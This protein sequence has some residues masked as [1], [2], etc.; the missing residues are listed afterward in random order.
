MG[1]VIGSQDQGQV[2][3]AEE[4]EKHNLRRPQAGKSLMEEGHWRWVLK[5]TQS[6][7]VEGFPHTGSEL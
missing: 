4:E 5:P 2:T 1:P 6:L 7:L 3:Q